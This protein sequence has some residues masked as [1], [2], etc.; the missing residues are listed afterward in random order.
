MKEPL[1]NI[2]MT[3]KKHASKPMDYKGPLEDLIGKFVKRSFR[4]E[5]ELI[6][7]M[8]VKV[9]SVDGDTITGILENDPLFVKGLVCGDEITVERGQIEEVYKE[10]DQ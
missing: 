1:S 8:W 2:G 5:T 10:E 4:T 9:V 7:H 6:E 3:C